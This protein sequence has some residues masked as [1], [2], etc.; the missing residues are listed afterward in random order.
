M[1]FT[2][3]TSAPFNLA[4]NSTAAF[5]FACPA[6]RASG[7]GFYTPDPVFVQI[8]GS[9]PQ[10]NNQWRVWARNTSAAARTVYV[11][12]QCVTTDPGTVVANKQAQ[13]SKGAIK[14]AG[15]GTNPR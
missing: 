7:G 12:I 5:D 15:G 2:N 11:W 14:K 4:A 3:A 8:Y 9:L 13:P 6:G 1:F 10:G